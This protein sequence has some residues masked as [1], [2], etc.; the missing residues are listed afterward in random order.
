MSPASVGVGVVIPVR[1]GERYLGET[2]ES[3]CTQDPA[4]CDVVVV[5]DGSDDGTLDLLRS[6]PGPVRV[7]RQEQL[8]LGVALNRGVDA[9]D[10]EIVGFCDADDLWT[11]GR[12]AIQLAALDDDPTAGGVSGMVEQ[13]ISPD[14][15]GLEGR[16][17]F[18][19]APQAGRLLGAV[20]VRAAT[21]A[22]V[23]SFDEILDNT[24]VDWIARADGSG[25]R[26]A[27]VDRVVLR[28]RIHGANWSMLN[29]EK[30]RAALLLAVRRDRE[31]RLGDG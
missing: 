31:R 18:D 8:G 23:G 2:L 9:I 14:S 28:R 10:A 4:P 22:A 1:N 7:L 11:P 16:V 24:P 30:S 13:F 26:F 3:I 25:T 27:A 12:L 20:L 19:P 15:P 17:R 29:G 21:L 5:D 6:A